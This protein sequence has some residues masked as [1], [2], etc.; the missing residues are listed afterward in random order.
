MTLA[1]LTLL[2]FSIAI[3]IFWSGLFSGLETALFSLKPHQVRRLEE[4][5]PSLK[6]FIQVFRENPRRVLNVLLLADALA[7]IPLVV[8]WSQTCSRTS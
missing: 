8:L 4:K 5:Y 2:L 3:L 7:N 6:Q 1:A